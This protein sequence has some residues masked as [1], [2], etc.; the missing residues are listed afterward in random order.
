MNSSG[1]REDPGGVEKGLTLCMRFGKLWSF[2]RFQAKSAA[3]IWL[4]LLLDRGGVLG[5]GGAPC[6]NVPLLWQM[7]CGP[8]HMARTWVAH[9]SDQPVTARGC[10]CANCRGQLHV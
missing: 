1:R 8:W 3:S 5:V 7:Q 4:E 9:E 6:F 10:P 2:Y